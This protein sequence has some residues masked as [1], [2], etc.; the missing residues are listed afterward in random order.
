MRLPDLNQYPSVL[1][2]D[3]INEIFDSVLDQLGR[4]KQI[5]DTNK[6]VTYFIKV[7]H[8]QGYRP[9]ISLRQDLAIKVLKY[10]KNWWDESNVELCESI[11]TLSANLE[12]SAALIFLK[13]KKKS[14]KNLKIKKE[15][16]EAVNEIIKS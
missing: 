15:I 12:I 11:I 4:A 2:F 7:I 16:L 9:G 1:E 3:Q 8:S 10:L 5:G 6:I 13:E 14:T